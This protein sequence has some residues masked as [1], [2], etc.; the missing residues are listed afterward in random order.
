MTGPRVKHREQRPWAAAVLCPV[1]PL[2]D[3][4]QEEDLSPQHPTSTFHLTGEDSGYFRCPSPGPGPSPSRL[5]TYRACGVRLRLRASITRA[6]GLW[7]GKWAQQ[8][9]RPVLGQQNDQRGRL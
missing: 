4:S 8:C 9:Q 1:L 2:P 3:L 6:L 7:S 5:P